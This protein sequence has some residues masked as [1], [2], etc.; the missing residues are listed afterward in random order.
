MNTTAR[1]LKRQNINVRKKEN[2]RETKARKLKRKNSNVLEKERL[3][4]Q[5]KRYTI[6]YNENEKLHNREQKRKKRTDVVYCNKQIE[7]QRQRRFGEH[8]DACIK[9]FHEQIRHGSIFVCSCCQQTW[10]KESVLK[11]ENTKLDERIKNKYLTSTFSVENLE[12]VCNTCYSSLR[13]NRTPKLSVLNGM[14]WP[15]KPIELDLFPLEER[16]VSLRIPFMQIRELPRG[17]QYSAR[18]NVVNVP[19]DIQP[20]INSLPRKLDENVT[21]PVKLKKNYLIKNAILMKMYD[22]QKY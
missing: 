13:E 17:G 7:Q 1:K 15:L 5:V 22:R 12:W 11:V 10:F 4:K 8:I 18:G 2:E 16:L 6:S 19:V 20:T 21:I 14:T 3:T 9:N